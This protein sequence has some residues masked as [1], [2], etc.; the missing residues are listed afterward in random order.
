MTLQE[1][2]QRK[3]KTIK[4]F[5]EAYGCGASKASGILRGLY[6]TTLS[7]DEVKHLAE[8]LGISFVECADA[9]D[10]TFAELKH[11][12]GDD[13][14]KTARTHKG[15][16]ERWRWVDE[17]LRDTDKAAKSGDWTEYRKKYAP[18]FTDERQYY[19]SCFAILGIPPNAT[20]EQIKAAFRSKV[21]ASHEQGHFTGDM[22]KLVQ[23]KEK[24][25]ASIGRK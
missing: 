12:K 13:W 16:W 19:S 6:H 14:K 5:A 10:N 7:K 11:Y 23:A 1:Y 24:A 22:D 21:K 4:A 17:L 15:I 25:L 9:C 20:V 18:P 2:R 8:V 3:F